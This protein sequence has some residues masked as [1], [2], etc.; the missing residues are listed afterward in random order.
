MSDNQPTENP[1]EEMNLKGGWQRPA[2][3][4]G[5]QVPRSEPETPTGGWKVPAMPTDLEVQPVSEGDWHLPR[6]EDTSFTPGDE[7]EIGVTSPLR[8]EDIDLPTQSAAL[9]V[10]APTEAEP[11]ATFDPEAYTG[12]GDLVA[13]L[14]EQQEQAPPEIMPGEPEETAGTLEAESGLEEL[15]AELMEEQQPPPE[16]ML[17]EMEGEQ[18]TADL[19]QPA[20]AERAALEQVAEEEEE[21]PVGEQPTEVHPE[22]YARQ[23]VD[24]LHSEDETAATDPEAYAREQLAALMGEAEPPP[25]TETGPADYARQQLEQLTPEEAAASALSAKFRETEAKVR[26]LR[27]QYQNGQITRDQLQTELRNYLILDDDENW[28]MMG[29][30]TDTWY[31]YDNAAGTWVPDQPP[32]VAEPPVPT[33]TGQFTPDQVLQGSLPYLPEDD[34]IPE[35]SDEATAA[36]GSATEPYYPDTDMPLPREVP[37]IDPDATIPGA[38]AINQDYVRASD[39]ETLDNFYSQPT[40]AAQPVDV[41]ALETP[42]VEPPDYS[43]EGES[44]AFRQAEERQRRTM[45]QRVLL[46]GTLVIGGLFIIGIIGLLYILVAYNSR[47]SL[48]RSNIA[49]LANYQPDFQTVRIL[50]TNDDTIAELN[51]GGARASVDLEDMSAD[52]IYAIVGSQDPGF[53]EAS[54]FEPFV[55]VDAFVRSLR[56]QAAID[57]D[58]LTITQQVAQLVIADSAN[59]NTASTLDTI[60]VASEIALQYDKNFILELFLNEES[61]G[62]QTFGLQAAADFYFDKSARQ[63]NLVEGSL[64]AAI[65][66]D[67]TNDPVQQRDRAFAATEALLRELATVGCLRFQHP[68]VT[69]GRYCGGDGILRANS[70]FRGEITLDVARLE[71]RPYLPRSAAGDYPH[72]V[73]Y[74]RFQLEQAYPERLFRE[75]FVVR[76]T[77]D[78]EIQDLAERTLRQQLE[79]QASTGLQTGAVMV[80]QPGSGNI[81]AMVGSPDFNNTDIDGSTNNAFTWQLPGTTILPVVYGAAFQGVGDRNGNGGID[82]TEYITPST[83]L[84]DLPREFQSTG[85]PVVNANNQFLGPVS[86]RQALAN[87]LRPPAVRTYEFVGNENFTTLAQNMGLNFRQGASLGPATGVGDLTEVRLFDLMQVYSVLAHNGQYTPLR[88]ITGITNADNQI[89]AL[90]E[91][92]Q[93]GQAINAISPQIAFLLQNILSDRSAHAGDLQ[94]IFLGNYP[95]RVAVKMNGVGDQVDMWTI[96]FSRNA[97]VGVWMGRPDNNATLANSRDAALPVFQA[98][99]SATLQGTNPLPFDNP[100]YSG[101]QAGSVNSQVIC[102]PTGTLPQNCSQQRNEFF[103]ASR[104][105]APAGSLVVQALIDTWSRRLANE[106]CRD[107]VIQAE[108]VRLIPRDLGAT[109]WLNTTTGRSVANL[110]GLPNPVQEMPTEG[111]DLNTTIPVAQITSPTENTAV[112]DTVQI[113]G[114]ASAQNFGNYTV[115]YA[116]ANTNNYQ[117]IAGPVTV[118]QTQPNSVLAEWNT[119]IGP[120]P[121][122]AYVLRLTM[123]ANSGNGYIQRTVPISVL[124]QP[125][126]TPIPPTSTPIPTLI[127]TVLPIFPTD[128]VIPIQPEPVQPTLDN[129]SQ[130]VPGG[131]TPTLF[132]GSDP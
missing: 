110:M 121:N 63:L 131:P 5:W 107:S 106:F 48:F 111:C 65:L 96:G 86:A 9:A 6:P 32:I 105:P 77:L 79:R 49:Q 124:N 115:E 62:N 4:G 17:E 42:A 128:T 118:Q 43:L 95:D 100:S 103:A 35:F 114:I 12:L 101:V 52:A 123:N 92:L 11:R 120:V 90:T 15:V 2:K 3:T 23:Q 68:D 19:T 40:I 126:P 29:V 122:G 93:P 18:E 116:P 130:G 13:Q 21:A 73:D 70:S 28:W 55:V 94:P 36:T 25:A 83:I 85:Y 44:E 1:S 16:I 34:G 47:A 22:D 60:I 78:P 125:T 104:P 109:A 10:A 80:V 46:L 39:A 97:V 7:L 76:T 66:R 38:A 108:F 132:F 64:L 84:F 117:R 72:F 56:G 33:E 61:F 98:I 41:G 75:G 88:A 24:W 57:A 129:G 113:L 45:L 31:R 102:I 67:Y 14:M 127:P 69:G 89:V 30:D 112:S 37:Y 119:L 50:D 82:F 54:G 87:S 8:P 59:S 27:Q 20:A 99:M 26:G 58:N 53:F 81:L 71:V 51:S 91:S 74:V